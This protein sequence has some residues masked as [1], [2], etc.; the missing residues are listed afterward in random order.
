MTVDANYEGREDTL[1]L[2]ASMNCEAPA[3]DP[4]EAERIRLKYERVSKLPSQ[5]VA[6]MKVAIALSD[7]ALRLVDSV[8][9]RDASC[10][11]FL[12]WHSS[13]PN[14]IPAV[15]FGIDS[16]RLD[17]NEAHDER[18][19]RNNV[20]G[21]FC[22]QPIVGLDELGMEVDQQREAQR[23]VDSSS[24]TSVPAEV[25]PGELR[26]DDGIIRRVTTAEA[27]GD[28]YYNQ[29]YTEENTRRISIAEA[30]QLSKD[31]LLVF[32]RPNKRVGEGEYALVTEETQDET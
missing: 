2:P 18:V 14:S 23:L 9:M 4:E 12:P 21:S 7:E 10:G 27:I 19:Q 6:D 22:G 16:P 1:F 25:L 8:R 31:G 15:T 17:I 28:T 30:Q 11:P 32:Y 20:K 5:L 29:E 24:G 3:V 26:C 13:P